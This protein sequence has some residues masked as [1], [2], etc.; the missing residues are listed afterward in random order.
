MRSTATSALFIALILVA[1][2]CSDRSTKQNLPTPP[3]PVT[4]KISIADLGPPL[5]DLGLQALPTPD[6]VIKSVSIGTEDPFRNISTGTSASDQT[7]EDGKSEF[8]TFTLTGFLST[9]KRQLALIEFNGESGT[10]FV[11]DKGSITTNLLPPGWTVTSIDGDNGKLVLR[12]K[13]QFVTA[14]I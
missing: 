3:L 13:D 12:K 1:T 6:E 11:G 2:A 7:S 9:S 4:S 5:P 8:G 14:E 10:V